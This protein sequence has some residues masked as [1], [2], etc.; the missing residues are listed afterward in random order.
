MIDKNKTQ[1]KGFTLVEV[2]IASAI[3]TILMFALMQ[4][5]QKGIVLSSQAL[6]K[7]KASFLAEEGVE[8]VKSIRDND[9][10][11][12]ANLSLNTNYYLSFNS[13]TKKW[14]LNNTNNIIDS[15]FTRSIVFNSVNRD[16]NDDIVSSGGSLDGLTKKVTVEV[17]W[18]SYGVSN[19]K[20]LS[21]YVANI[22]D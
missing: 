15:Q 6:E 21:F 14:E 12:I 22:F 11:T 8:A 10:N 4:A 5:A 16:S 19:N 1:Q 9:W 18:S 3:I 13:N 20:N 2:I 17:S 7:T